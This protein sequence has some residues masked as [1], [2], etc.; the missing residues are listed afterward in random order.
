MTKKGHQ[1]FG[2]EESAEKILDNAIT[3]SSYD[4]L[5][6]ITGQHFRTQA[7]TIFYGPEQALILIT[8]ETCVGRFSMTTLQR[9][10]QQRNSNFTS[11]VTYRYDDF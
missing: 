1:I 4:L 10:K 5:K 9:N 7:A 11:S 2:Q 8:A 3:Q 6:V